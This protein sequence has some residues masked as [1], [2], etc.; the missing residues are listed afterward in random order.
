MEQLLS[1]CIIMSK[2]SGYD[3]ICKLL[4]NVIMFSCAM[5]IFQCCWL[6]IALKVYIDCYES[7]EI[8]H[9]LSDF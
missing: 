3:Q 9:L 5:L 4:S 6:Y 7:L 8:N 1:H 2:G